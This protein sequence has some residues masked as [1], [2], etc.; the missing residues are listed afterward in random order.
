MHRF[1]LAVK[2]IS[3]LPTVFFVEM[4]TWKIVTLIVRAVLV[5]AELGREKRDS[6]CERWL[7]AAMEKVI[8]QICRGRVEQI[9]NFVDSRETLRMRLAARPLQ[10]NCMLASTQSSHVGSRRNSY[11]MCQEILTLSTTTCQ[12]KEN[13]LQLARHEFLNLTQVAKAENGQANARRKNVG[14]QP[15]LS[16][17]LCVLLCHHE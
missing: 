15:V 1:F 9:L 5:V 14:F 12:P 4:A 17:C 16:P 11:T 10:R 2:G 13:S 6:H 3:V 7:K 8:V